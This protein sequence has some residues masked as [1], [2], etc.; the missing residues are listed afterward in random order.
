MSFCLETA[1]SVLTENV[2]LSCKVVDNS[3]RPYQKRC[4]RTGCM[5]LTRRIGDPNLV[6]ARVLLDS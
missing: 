3:N 6:I 2:H 1:V 5:F 4:I